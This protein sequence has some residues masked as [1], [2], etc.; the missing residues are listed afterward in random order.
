M[1][2]RRIL[3]GL[4]FFTASIGF[5]ALAE[6]TPSSVLTKQKSS[7][8]KTA[9]IKKEAVPPADLVVN[10][11]ELEKQEVKQ[12][13]ILSAIY[14]LNKKIKKIVTQRAQFSEKAAFLEQGVRNSE[15]K[16][17][18]IEQSISEQRGLLGERLRALYKLNSSSIA[19]FLF[20]ASNPSTLDRNLK[21]LGIVTGYDAE[22][23][24]NY[25]NDIKKAKS[26]KNKL[27]KDLESLHEA[28]ERYAAQ[29]AEL[30]KEQALKHKLLEGIRKRKLFAQEKI[31]SLKEL[32]RSMNIQDENVV[33]LLF[34]PSIYEFKGTLPRPLSGRPLTKFGLIKDEQHPYTLFNKGVHFSAESGENV[35]AVYAGVV[36]H[37]DDIEGVGKTIII[38]HGD[39]YY[40]VY[41]GMSQFMVEAGDKVQ[42]GQSIAIMG[43]QSAVE[44]KIT[45]YFEFRHFSEPENPLSW[46]KG[47]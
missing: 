3:A 21:I 9:S 7:K 45:M 46:M 10:K 23:L 12:R 24:R 29:E 15:R 18:E 41:S 30:R 33:D 1:R 34:R 40:S 37:A 8:S 31:N 36:S 13:Q 38:N 16:I 47:L 32:S 11:A 35:K 27:Q 26:E 2:L 19:K 44:D 14:Q 5:F 17:Q 22:L 25:A 6:K 20:T 28:N 4:L 42:Q 39:H 43:S